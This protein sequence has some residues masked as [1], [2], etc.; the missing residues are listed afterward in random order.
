MMITPKTTTKVETATDRETTAATTEMTETW[1]DTTSTVHHIKE[2]NVI[3]PA[4][5]EA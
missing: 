1:V 2:K 4:T 5:E 3:H